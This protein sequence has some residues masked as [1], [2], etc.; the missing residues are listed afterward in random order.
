MKA[1][2][3]VILILSILLLGALGYIGYVKYNE[4]SQQKQQ[5]QI[6]G[7]AS[8]GYQQAIVDIASLATS[9]EPVPLI[10]GN[11]TIE[12]VAVACIQSSQ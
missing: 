2:T 8:L 10:I 3:T 12:M 9:C 4:Y 11:E 5:Q 1:Q 6:L 7:Y